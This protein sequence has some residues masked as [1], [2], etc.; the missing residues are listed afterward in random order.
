MEPAEALGQGDALA[1]VERCP[2]ELDQVPKGDDEEHEREREAL[3]DVY[4]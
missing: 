4:A 3:H 1:E 2:A